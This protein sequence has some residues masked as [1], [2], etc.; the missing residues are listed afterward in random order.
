MNT[1]KNCV[2]WAVRWERE[3]SHERVWSWQVTAVED[4]G[5]TSI[6]CRTYLMISG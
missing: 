5:P 6:H 3:G 4:W 1:R 2:K